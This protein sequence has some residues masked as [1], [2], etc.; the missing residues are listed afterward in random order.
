MKTEF[1]MKS[2]LFRLDLLDIFIN[3]NEK[4]NLIRLKVEKNYI[5]L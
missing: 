4:L 5:N 3:L 1:R 2:K